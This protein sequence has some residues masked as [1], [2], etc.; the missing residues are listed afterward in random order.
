VRM[1]SLQLI[2]LIALA[3]ATL[4]SQPTNGPVYWSPVNPNL[5]PLDCSS[6][7]GESPVAIT[8]SSG[9]TIGYSCYVSGTFVWLAAGGG[10]HTSIR[11][12]APA[13]A[14]IGVDY[15]FYDTSGNN[16][17][18]NT[19]F[20]SGSPTTSGTGVNFALSANQPAEVGLLG[21]TSNAPQYGATSTGSVYAVFYCPDAATCA[22]VLPQLL[23]STLPTNSWLL[24]VPISWDTELWTQWSAEGIDDGSTHRVSLAIYNEDTTATSYTVRV[25]DS[26]GSLAGTGTTPSIPPLQT[27]PDGSLGE[28][29][30]YGALLS[31]VI[32]TPL[33]PGLFKV[34]VDGGLKYSAVE[35]LQFDGSAA[36][37][38]QVAYDSAPRSSSSLG[39]APLRRANVRSARVASMPK[40]VFSALEK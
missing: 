27:L 40:P 12:A 32:S 4:H 21:A 31:D 18:L 13:S 2:G 14:A 35:V 15:T 25:Y 10:W 38:L 6:L 26:T 11:V 39:A 17:T 30:T 22:N 33:P 9:T 36:A 19:T 20:G 28:G 1:K 24:S 8:N 3:A 29:G 7:A 5:P 16:L 34:L 37:A 23:Y